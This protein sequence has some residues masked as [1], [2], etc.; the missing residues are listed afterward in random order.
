MHNGPM[1]FFLSLYYYGSSKLHWNHCLK[2]VLNIC[3]LDKNVPEMEFNFYVQVF[4]FGWSP[5]CGMSV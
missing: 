1:H 4:V 5:Y 3:C 2:S